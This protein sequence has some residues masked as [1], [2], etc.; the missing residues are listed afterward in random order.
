MRYEQGQG[1][2]TVTTE[3]DFLRERVAPEEYEAFRRWLGDADAI[4]RQRLVVRG[5]GGAP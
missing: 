2:V 4:L 3:L 1:T 5:P